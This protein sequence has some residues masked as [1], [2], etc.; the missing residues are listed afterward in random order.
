M[1]E[2]YRESMGRYHIVLPLW[3]ILGITLSAS[4]CTTMAFGMFNVYLVYQWYRMT[5]LDGPVLHGSTCGTQ[6]GTLWDSSGS[7]PQ[8]SCLRSYLSMLHDVGRQQQLHSLKIETLLKLYCQ[9]SQ[10]ELT[11]S[12]IAFFLHVCVL[13]PMARNTAYAAALKA[14]K[15]PELVCFLAR[16]RCF[17]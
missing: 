16:F 13:D 5:G 11:V 12:N 8:L 14:S 2:T 3:T 10:S 9:I 7:V 4:L 15:K 6:P 1:N 17:V